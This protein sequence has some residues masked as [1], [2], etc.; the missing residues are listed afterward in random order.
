MFSGGRAEAGLF[1]WR[2]LSVERGQGSAGGAA[3]PA[4][5][6]AATVAQ[7]GLALKQIGFDRVNGPPADADGDGECVLHGR[8]A[9][10]VVRVAIG[11][12]KPAERRLELPLA[13]A[14]QLAEA[15]ALV[16]ADLLAVELKEVAR[17]R[18]PRVVPVPTPPPSS[19]WATPTPKP[20]K[21]LD[22]PS[23]PDKPATTPEPDRPATWPQP[24]HPRSAPSVPARPVTTPV[25]RRQKPKPDLVR[26]G[27]PEALFEVG[28]TLTVGYVGEPLFGGA[29]VRVAAVRRPLLIGG[30]L[31]V[32]GAAAEVGR[33]SLSLTRVLVGP[34][35]G[36]G[37]ARKRVWLDLDLSPQLALLFVDAGPR[38]RHT[39]VTGAVALGLHLDVDLHAGWGLGLGVELS[40]AFTRLTVMAPEQTTPVAALGLG[41]IGFSVGLSKAPRH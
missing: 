6:K 30:G 35:I 14:D 10:C 16:I 31:S 7:L 15:L 2:G 3:T 34:R 41:S 9:S 39:L 4:G 29:S 18:T 36:V 40:V 22:K 21:P 27:P 17:P 38:G 20:A 26:L 1:H 24:D 8:V 23:Q 12:G 33:G 5:I 19:A 32:S 13:D 11:A 28:G 25:Q 37:L